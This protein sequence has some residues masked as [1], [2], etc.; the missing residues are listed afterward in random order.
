[1]SNETKNVVPVVPASSVPASLVRPRSRIPAGGIEPGTLSGRRDF[2][3]APQEDP[4]AEHIE[5]LR[6]VGKMSAVDFKTFKSSPENLK[7]LDAAQRFKKE[8]HV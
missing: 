5:L 6:R 4:A 3:P 2:N 8:G 1:M 7:A